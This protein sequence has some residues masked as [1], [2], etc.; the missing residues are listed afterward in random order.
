M[1]PQ[2][3]PVIEV[4]PAPVPVNVNPLI[5]VDPAQVIVNPTLG[6]LSFRKNCT[7]IDGGIYTFIN[8]ETISTPFHGSGPADVYPSIIPVSGVPNII[9]KVKVTL[10]DLESLAPSD[11]VILLVGPNNVTN[12]C[13]MSQAGGSLVPINNVFLTFDDAANDFVPIYGPLIT[14]TFKP[15]CFFGIVDLPSAPPT[16]SSISLSNFIGQNPNGDWKLFVISHNPISEL[17]SLIRSGWAISIT[18]ADNEECLYNS[19]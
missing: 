10:F 19:L 17:S 14:G 11:F 12:T 8:N 16:S 6:F 9:Q 1:N 13:L 4:A 7:Q 18:T 3:A 2:I 15:S 5:Q